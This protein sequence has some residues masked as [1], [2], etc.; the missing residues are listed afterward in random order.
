MG[1]VGEGEGIHGVVWVWW[2][3][4]RDWRGACRVC[5]MISE[6]WLLWRVR[7]G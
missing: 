7:V 1:V 3:R 4:G 5:G 2:V 6:R